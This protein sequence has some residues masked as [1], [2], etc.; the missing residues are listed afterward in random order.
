MKSKTCIIGLKYKGRVYI[1]G[2][3]QGTGGYEKMTMLGR[4]VFRLGDMLLG[5]CGSYRAG[6]ILKYSLKLP[7]HPTGAD[8]HKYLCTTFI[9]SVRTAFKKGGI[10]EVE[11]QTE[12]GH[13]FI[14]GYKKRLFGIYSDNQVWESKMFLSM[15]CGAEYAYGA[16]AAV[17]GD[18]RKRI[19]KALKVSGMFS[20]GVGPPYYVEVL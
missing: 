10:L 15:G 19:I 17:G 2:D 14:I 7:P 5:Y 1:G 6:Q 11:N 16:L 12:T 20:T 9:N 3:S 13:D 8:A 18:P 4:K